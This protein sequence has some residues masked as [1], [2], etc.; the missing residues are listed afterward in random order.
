MITTKTAVYFDMAT[1][2][3]QTIIKRSNPNHAPVPKNKLSKSASASAFT[4]EINMAI[5]NSKA[6]NK[7]T[8]FKPITTP[9]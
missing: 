5:I 3:E 4:G 2:A 8:G 1:K 9:L 6:M 7:R